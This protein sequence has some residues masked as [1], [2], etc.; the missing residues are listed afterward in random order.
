MTEM[1]NTHTLGNPRTEEQKLQV[2]LVQKEAQIRMLRYALLQAPPKR[3]LLDHR[4]DKYVDTIL[5]PALAGTLTVPDHWN[6]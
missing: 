5:E 3:A 4:Y 2:R 6:A 1:G